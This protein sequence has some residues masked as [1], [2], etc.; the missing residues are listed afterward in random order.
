MES[1]STKKD[2]NDKDVEIV[3][4]FIICH[5]KNVPEE[6]VDLIMKI[7]KDAQ[8]IKL[9]CEACYPCPMG[10]V[11]CNED[12]KP[13]GHGSSKRCPECGVP[14]VDVHPHSNVCS[15]GTPIDT[16]MMHDEHNLHIQLEWTKEKY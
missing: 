2:G 16:R 5:H 4:D 14:Y 8:E 11:G 9:R 15:L 6:E 10:A 7:V 13:H 12:R 1:K 3:G